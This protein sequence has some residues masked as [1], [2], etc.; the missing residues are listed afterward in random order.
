MMGVDSHYPDMGPD[1]PP[2]GIGEDTEIRNAIIDKNARIGR[3]VKILNREGVRE[4]D[5]DGWVI[6]DGVVVIAKNTV[7]PD[8]TEI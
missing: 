7:L 5:G 2:V 3:G 4:A 6:R 1:A 8:G